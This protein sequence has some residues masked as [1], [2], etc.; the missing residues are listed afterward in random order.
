MSYAVSVTA[1][2]ENDLSAILSYLLE[3]LKTPSGA[4]HLLD[5]FEKLVES[6]AK[7]PYA[8]PKV[9]DELLAT[10]GYQWAPV[11]SY[12]VFFTIEESTGTVTIERILHGKQNWRNLIE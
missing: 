7:M 10:I 6:V 9:R 3:S 12:M 4:Q 1:S 2:A 11:S 8:Y 5:D